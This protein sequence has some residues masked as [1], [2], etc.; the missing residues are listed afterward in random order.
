MLI[1]Y[2]SHKQKAFGILIFKSMRDLE[3]KKFDNCCYQETD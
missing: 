3:A 2:N 1:S